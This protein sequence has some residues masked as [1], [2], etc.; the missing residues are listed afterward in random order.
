MLLPNSMVDIL[1]AG[2]GLIVDAGPLIPHTLV[3][4]AAA[5]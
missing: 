4:M 3:E 1:A 2:G 5:A